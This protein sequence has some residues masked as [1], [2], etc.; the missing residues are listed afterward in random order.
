M[1]FYFDD[2]EPKYAE[3]W[4]K[5]YC[6]H[7][8]G[9][10]R[11]KSALLE[12]FQRKIL[13]QSLGW[14]IKENGFYKYSTIYVFIPRG[15]AKSTTSQWFGTYKAFGAGIEAARAYA[16]ASSKDQ[17]AGALFQPVK[18]MVQSHPVLSEE[19]LPF[20]NSVKDPHTDS[21]YKL[22][23]AEWRN[24]HSL[25]PSDV[26]VD[27]LHL[28]L[29]SKLMDG[30][31][32]G[33]AKRTDCTPQVRVWT[34]A[35]EINT[36]AHTFHKYAE[37]V[38]A[39]LIKDDS[40]LP[41]LFRADPDDDPFDPKTWEKA[42]PGWNFINQREFKEMA[43]RAERNPALL[44]T[45]KRYNLNM[46]TGSTESWIPPHEWSLGN[47]GVSFSEVRGYPCYGGLM[48][49]RVRDIN[50]FCLFFPDFDQ[51]FWWYWCPITS[52]NARKANTP[53]YVD[54]VED[55]YIIEVEGTTLKDDPVVDRIQEISKHVHIKEIAYNGSEA[56]S[57]IQAL[58]DLDFNMVPQSISS[59][60]HMSAPAKEIE[61]RLLEGKIKH[62]G[63]PV[64]AFQIEC[65]QMDIKDDMI[66]PS[67]KESKDNICGVYAAIMAMGGWMNADLQ[68]PSV[69][70]DR[71]MI[72]L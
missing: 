69:Y 50:A 32:S 44:N 27:E 25:I 68:G 13:E 1:E 58:E 15:N 57:K 62:G 49:S 11:G 14:K 18:E 9:A 30:I 24:A 28:Q 42:N 45:F 71:G 54:W 47:D 21:F 12:P 39:G 17:A 59:Y 19:L 2:E 20:H 29:D 16:F 31:N 63:N 72:W 65:V 7:V 26:D 53:H 52:S 34:T 67:S 61:K 43:T 3:S 41:I 38:H 10:L 48:V 55:R 40:F 70:E 66:R 56:T 23:S 46:W 33:K 36:Y 22:M 35:G 5:E 6:T 37:Q 51:F 64:S 4:I 60:G 8:V